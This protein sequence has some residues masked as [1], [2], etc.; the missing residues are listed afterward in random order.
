MK[1]DEKRSIMGI[2]IIAVAV[3]LIVAV[4]LMIVSIFTKL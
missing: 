1:D 4:F 3:A 2:G